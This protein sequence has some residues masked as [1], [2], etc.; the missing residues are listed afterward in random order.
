MFDIKNTSYLA[1]KKAKQT[2]QTGESRSIRA[3]RFC[4]S[5]KPFVNE[6]RNNQHLVKSSGMKG[7]NFKK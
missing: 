2:V 4:S 3:F 5:D 6:R 1:K 7:F